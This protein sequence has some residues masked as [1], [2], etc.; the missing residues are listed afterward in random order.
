MFSTFLCHP[1]FFNVNILLVLYI[2]TLFVNLINSILSYRI[3]S[4]GD[5]AFEVI[6]L[7][8]MT[9]NSDIE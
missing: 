2:I 9:I 5:V 4:H 7:D 6:K 3:S 8:G 1:C